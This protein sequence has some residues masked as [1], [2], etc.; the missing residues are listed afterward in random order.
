MQRKI[1][2]GI[3]KD[4]IHTEGKREGGREQKHACTHTNMLIPS[5]L[6]KCSHKQYQTLTHERHTTHIA[7]SFSAVLAGDLLVCQPSRY[8]RMFRVGWRE[9]EEEEEESRGRNEGGREGE[10]CYCRDKHVWDYQ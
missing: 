8:C 9:E 7:V 4:N 3:G 6:H 10:M 1:G 5:Q 2:R